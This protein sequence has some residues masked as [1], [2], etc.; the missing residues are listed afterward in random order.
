MV[1]ANGYIEVGRKV[2][3]LVGRLGKANDD[4]KGPTTVAEFCDA[5]HT[6]HRPAAGRKCVGAQS[7]LPLR[8]RAFGP[9]ESPQRPTISRTSL[10]RSDRR[11]SIASTFAFLEKL[12]CR[13][14]I[15]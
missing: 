8:L 10:S 4:L 3:R 15:S 1:A 14:L 6:E 12:K 9:F 7:L 13:L 5:V 11:P 2:N